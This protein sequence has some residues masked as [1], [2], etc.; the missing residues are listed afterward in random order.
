MPDTTDPLDTLYSIPPGTPLID[1]LFPSE[2]RLTGPAPRSKR[3]GATERELELTRRRDADARLALVT[4]R[5][6]LSHLIDK[7][8]AFLGGDA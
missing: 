4:F 6:D 2:G 5:N 1:A 7:V 3:A 8:N